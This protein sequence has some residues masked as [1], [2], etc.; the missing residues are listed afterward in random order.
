[1]FFMNNFRNM[2]N[3]ELKNAV[4][5]LKD[6]MDS[7]MILKSYYCRSDEIFDF[8]NP[9]HKPGMYRLLGS[10]YFINA[11]TSET[12]LNYA[13]VLVIRYP[14]T[15]TVAMLAFPYSTG[16]IYYRAGTN[17]SFHRNAWKKITTQSI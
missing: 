1:M 10:N 16:N 6:T 12:E 5:N 14:T 4:S 15:D 2:Q 7:G 8:N 9:M 11:P 13:N 3:I 17:T